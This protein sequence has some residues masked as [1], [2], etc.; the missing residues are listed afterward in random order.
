MMLLWRIYQVAVLFI[1]LTNCRNSIIY[2]RKLQTR[3][4]TGRCP[5]S[6]WKFFKEM[7]FTQNRNKGARENAKNQ[8]KTKS[9]GASLVTIRSSEDYQF[10]KRTFTVDDNHWIGLNKKGKWWSGELF[11][12]DGSPVAYLK[13]GPYDPT[14]NGG[15]NCA[16][17]GIEGV[18]F[19]EWCNYNYPSFCSIAAKPP[20]T[21][22]TRPKPRTRPRT[23]AKSKSTLFGSIGGVGGLLIIV[24]GFIACKKYSAG[25]AYQDYGGYPAYGNYGASPLPY[26]Y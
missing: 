10:L 15:E 8:C 26:Q 24:I 2:S 14:D 6:E 21:T 19:D 11:W 18:Y 16:T 12:E 1:A 7:C 22:T 20:V 23:N 4:A 13:W 5:G 9:K 25:Q 3:Q 17:L